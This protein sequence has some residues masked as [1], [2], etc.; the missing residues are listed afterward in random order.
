MK[1]VIIFGGTGFIGFH[2]AVYCL[3]NN[4]VDSVVLAD[5]RD[6][7]FD[8]VTDKFK[9]YYY[10]GD[11]KFINCDV[12]RKIEIDVEFDIEFIV[13]L[14]A[15]HTTPGHETN[16]YYETN[17]NGAINVTAFAEM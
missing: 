7:D 16:E 2:Y 4:L 3:E 15:I 8:R 11:I 1:G 12:R 17:I 9:F 13:N 5:I 14:A 6:I 10:R